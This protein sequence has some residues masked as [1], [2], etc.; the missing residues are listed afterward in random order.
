MRVASF[1]GGFV[2][3]IAGAMPGGAQDPAA[4]EAS[5]VVIPA[6]PPKSVVRAR[7]LGIVPGVGH[8]Y[9]GENTHAVA[10]MLATYAAFAISAIGDGSGSPS[11]P[12]ND[13]EPLAACGETYR[14]STVSVIMLA[15]LVGWSVQDAGNAAKRWNVRHGHPATAR[16][17]PTISPSRVARDRIG[18]SLGLRVPIRYLSY[19]P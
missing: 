10:F 8:V 18:I 13:P 6:R 2:V 7:A 5:K 12:P 1:V 4:A 17:V 16:I 9:A 3:L 19:S 11:P 15:G 14:I